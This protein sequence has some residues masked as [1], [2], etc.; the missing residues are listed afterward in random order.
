M[1]LDNAAS[2]DSTMLNMPSNKLALSGQS[3]MALVRG[4]NRYLR[5]VQTGMAISGIYATWR[6]KGG[7]PSRLVDAHQR[8]A[9]R[10]A[11]LIRH[12]GG[13]W[14]KAAQFFSTRSDILPAAFIAELEQFQNN[15]D[16][17][18][19]SQ[20]KKVLKHNWGKHWQTHIAS[21]DPKPVA[22]ASIAQLHR[23]TL[24]NGEEVAIK[25]RLPG[26]KKLFLE[27]I[28]CFTLLAE[29]IAPYI[30]ELD[31]KQVVS[32]L[33][34]MTLGELNF[35]EEANNLSRF[36]RLPHIN[37]IRVPRLYSDLSSE[38]LLVTSWEEGDRLR[39]HLD[40]HP[41]EAPHLLNTL[42]G[43]YLQQVTRFGI[44]QADPHPGNFLVNNDGDIIIVDYGAMGWLSHQE[45]RRYSKLLYGLMGYGGDVNIGQ[46]FQD[47]GFA[48][49]TPEVLQSLSDY[50]FTDKLNHVNPLTAIEEVLSTF[51]KHN[52][53]IPDSYIGLSRVLI[54]LG[55]FMLAYKVP[56]N[57]APPEQRNA[58]SEADV[59]HSRQQRSGR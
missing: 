25:V 13:A 54:T 23:A 28:H 40:A 29:W 38:S 45:V 11:D 5:A 8:A 17:I 35:C 57:W 51:R 20:I 43:S 48:G 47:A 39:E 12:N 44:F 22:T 1:I 30:K 15:A 46:L 52:I 18:A 56:M 55:G 16:P 33:N 59:P 34:E 53:T 3:V 27:D 9:A 42:L 10:L 4:R 21:I 24:E 14:V 26:I 50:V 58:V 7:K 19:F 6:A 32:Q 31:I 41:E 37:G 36:G 49:G 2:K